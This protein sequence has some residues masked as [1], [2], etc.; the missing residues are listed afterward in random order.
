MV[1]RK[2]QLGIYKHYK[3]DL[4][5]VIGKALHSESLEE[6]VVY[7]H[8]SGKRAKEA[9]YWVR[10]LAMFLETVK[11]EGKRLPRFEYIRE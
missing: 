3:G 5:E 1:S 6:F 11:Y 2:V 9:Y 7:K 10:P 8:V 4:V